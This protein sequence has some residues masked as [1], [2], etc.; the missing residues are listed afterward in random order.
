MT[1]IYIFLIIFLIVGIAFIFVTTK[2]NK[3]ESA[4]RDKNAEVDSNIWDR[5]FHLSKITEILDATGIKNEIEAPDTSAFS[6]GTPAN[7]QA[8]TSEKLDKCSTQLMD[9]IK[10]HPE[11]TSN[12]DFNTHYS[13]FEKSRDDLFHSSIAYNKAVSAYNNFIS[14]FPG[15]MIATLR[16]KNEKP[17]FNYVF[18]E[19][20]KDSQG[21]DDLGI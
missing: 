2:I 8:I 21:L 4:T 7:L 5:G 13:K 17:R 3:L 18:V 16:K 19:L 20:K 11:L 12:E 1:G 9:I 15:S 14:S 10:E 6:L